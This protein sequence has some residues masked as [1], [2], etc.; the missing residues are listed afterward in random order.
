MGIRVICDGCG[1]DVTKQNYATIEINANMAGHG[2]DTSMSKFFCVDCAD[3]VLMVLNSAI[4]EAP[5]D[6]VKPS[7]SHADMGWVIS[8]SR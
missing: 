4:S 8:P 7:V 5:K 3:K 2:R 6:L 1:V